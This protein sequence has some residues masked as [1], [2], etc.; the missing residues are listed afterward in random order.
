[1]HPRRQF[2]LS[3][4]SW[5]VGTA[6][7]S[8]ARCGAAE[9]MA[10]PSPASRPKILKRDEG[11]T[12]WVTAGV[13]ITVKLRAEDTGGTYAVFQDF[14]LPGAG[15]DLHT[16]THE[17]ESLFVLEGK[18]RATVGDQ[19]SEVGPG[20]LVHMPLGVPHGFKNVSDQPAR[21]LMTYTPGGFEKY[22]LETGKPGRPD[23]E[24]PPSFTA[25]ER[26]KA[27]AVA[28]RLGVFSEKK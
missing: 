22:F 11:D 12:V 2:L 25:E 8:V 16:H 21:L 20:T 3:S 15:P 13:R 5:I 28:E 26:R 4:G 10:R 14:V 1:M 7:G 17:D 23:A 27:L 6:L 24:T 19:T 18:V 9:P